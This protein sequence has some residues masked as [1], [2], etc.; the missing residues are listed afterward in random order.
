MRPVDNKWPV[1]LGYGAAGNYAAGYHTGIDFGSPVGTPVHAVRRG[2]VIV[3]QYDKDYGNYVIVRGVFRR[4][5]WLYAHLSSR[6]VSVGKFVKN[7]QIIGHS[8][9]TGNATGPHVHV[10]QRHPPFGYWDHE[11]PTTF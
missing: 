11:K 6:A 8:G 5:A 9:E 7:G 10:E 4:R 2:Y 1:T 3:S